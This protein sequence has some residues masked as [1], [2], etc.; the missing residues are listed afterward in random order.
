MRFLKGRTVSPEKSDAD[1]AQQ[2]ALDI[3]EALRLA[4]KWRQRTAQERDVEEGL[5]ELWEQA[6]G[7]L[8]EQVSPGVYQTWL[9]RT[10][11]IDVQGTVAT[12]LV[13]SDFVQQR[14]RQRYSNPIQQA[15]KALLHTRVTLEYA[16][17]DG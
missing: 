3:D 7:L 9:A 2:E 14:I 10:L 5:V 1:G 4:R 11:L 17:M 12:I 15:L 8:H 6:Q 13:P 16:V